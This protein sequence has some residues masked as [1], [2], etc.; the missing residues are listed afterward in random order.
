MISF[1]GCRKDGGSAIALYDGHCEQKRFPYACGDLADDRNV[2]YPH[3]PPE[4]S[5]WSSAHSV[6]LRSGVNIRRKDAEGHELL[7][8]FGLRFNRVEYSPLLIKYNWD[9]R[10]KVVPETDFENSFIDF[11][12]GI[13]KW[14]GKQQIQASDKNRKKIEEQNLSYAASLR[15]LSKD[16]RRRLG[17]PR[18]TASQAYTTASWLY[19]TLEKGPERKTVWPHID[20]AD[21]RTAGPSDPKGNGVLETWLRIPPEPKPCFHPAFPYYN[22]QHAHPVQS[23]DSFPLNAEDLLQVPSP[24]TV[25]RHVERINSWYHGNKYKFMPDDKHKQCRRREVE[26]EM[27]CPKKKRLF[28]FILSK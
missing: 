17:P 16:T 3:Y 11:D 24:C 18:M 1:Q 6:N 7:W 13:A 28:L 12:F 5:C 26:D 25:S 14:F 27:T 9:A 19:H 23:S 4:I 15:T 20:D 2:V 21:N 8:V 22:A 10:S